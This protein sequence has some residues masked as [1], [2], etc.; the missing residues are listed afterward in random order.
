[1]KTVKKK[2]PRVVVQFTFKNTLNKVG[3]SFRGSTSET[4]HLIDK[5][6]IK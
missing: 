5:K 6:Y 1:M 3:D 2:L 4:K